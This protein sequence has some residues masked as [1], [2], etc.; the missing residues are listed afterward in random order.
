MIE[1]LNACQNLQ[2]LEIQLTD[3]VW[4]AFADAMGRRILKHVRLSKLMS[5]KMT[6]LPAAS[7]DY[8]IDFLAPSASS[9]QSLTV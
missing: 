8:L 4:S 1:F 9:M 6:I 3:G 2:E 5:F 7:I